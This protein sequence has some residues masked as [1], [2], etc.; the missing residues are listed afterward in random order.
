MIR[1]L[2]HPLRQ[3]HGQLWPALVQSTYFIH[4]AYRIRRQ[5]RR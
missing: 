3:R 2:K 1:Q 5:I 4:E